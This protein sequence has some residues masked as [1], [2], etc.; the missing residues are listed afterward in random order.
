IE[1]SRVSVGDQ[2]NYGFEIHGTLGALYWDFR[3][4]GELGVSAGVDYV[5]EAMRT[6]LVGPA[7]G[8][9]A[10]FQPGA[11]ITMGYDDLKVIEASRFLRSI[12]EGKPHGATV[13]DAVRAAQVVDAIAESAESR[14]WVQLR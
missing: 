8:D 14:R 7:H 13:T 11:G 5:D 3:R 6:V 2:C 12:A 1:S 4:M 9:L 10:A